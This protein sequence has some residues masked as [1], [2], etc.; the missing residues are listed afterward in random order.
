MAKVWV[1]P[2]RWAV[3]VTTGLAALLLAMLRQRRSRSTGSGKAHA[4]GSALR[5]RGHGCAIDTI[6]GEELT[7][8]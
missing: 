3:D 8:C 6:V 5:E 7:A 2:V 4:L 1:G